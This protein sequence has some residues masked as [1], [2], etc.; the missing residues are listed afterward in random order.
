VPSLH[1]WAAYKHEGAAAALSQGMWEKG[2]KGV[3][4]AA[5]LLQG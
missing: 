2:R 4:E 3:S 1:P 5:W